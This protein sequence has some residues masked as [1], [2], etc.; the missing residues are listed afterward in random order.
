MHYLKVQIKDSIPF[1]YR[2][3]PTFDN[4]Q[5]L[6][7][8]LKPKLKYK[9]DPATRE[10][11]Q[12]FQTLMKNG[13]RGDCDCFTIAATACMIVQGWDGIYVDLVGYDKEMPVHIYNDII[14]DGKR[15]VLDFTNPSFDTER[16]HGRKGKYKYRQRLYVDWNKWNF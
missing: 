7:N 14:F 9:N 12:T 16:T 2:Y 13:G 11:F 3:C 6:W 8:W 15:N 4:P 1:A 10:L 5:Q